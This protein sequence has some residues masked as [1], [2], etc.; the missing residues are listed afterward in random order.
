MFKEWK[1]KKRSAKSFSRRI[2]KVWIFGIAVPL[3]IVE[4]LILWQFYRINHNDVDKEIENSLNMV[5]NNISVLMKSMNSISWL[6]EADGTVGK[7]L[8]LYFEEEN[9]VKKGDLL[10][11]LQEQIAN[12]EVANP[13]IGNLTYIFLSKDRKMPEKINQSSLANGELP[14][15]KDYLCK[16]KNVTFYGP[17]PSKSKAGSYPCLSLLRSYKIDQKRGNIYIYLESGYKYF[18]K[19][20]PEGIMGMDT[21]F[22]IESENGATMY[23]SDENLVPLYSRTDDYLNNLTVNTHRYKAYEKT[24]EGGWKIHLWVPV[25]EY[26]RQIYGMALNFGFVTILAVIVCIFV[27]IIQWRSIYRPFTR[28]EKKLQLIASDN[29]VETKVEQM[30]IQEF[31]DSF[32][33]LEKMKKNILLLLNRVQIEEKRRSELEIKEVLGKINPHFLYNTLDTLK[34]YAAGKSDKEMVHFITALNRLLLYNMSKTTETTLKS[35]LD[36]VNAYIV[37]QKLKYDIDFQ[38]DTGKHKEILQADMPR[39]VLQPL[40]ENAILHSGSN[41]GKIGIEVELLANG[42]IAILVK[43]DGIPINPEKIKE[44]LLQKNDISSNGIGLQYVVRMLENRFGDEFELKAERTED[45][46]NV[47][48]IRI[49]FE[50]EEIVKK[51]DTFGEGASGK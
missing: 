15:E 45:G 8:H 32:A 13:S 30:N 39:F 18:Q 4:A 46:M 37:L 29:D 23:C 24:E 42:K 31:D 33:L 7:N 6:L 10:I 38:V 9:T 2:I 51:S 14:E 44:V 50:A 5:S 28:F 25:K 40:V 21:V 35:E 12:Y 48:E 11:Y 20:I 49:P 47:V 43:N 36:A 1:G 41:R 17:H 19:L 34:W 27:S 3:L 22:L 16:W 26:Y